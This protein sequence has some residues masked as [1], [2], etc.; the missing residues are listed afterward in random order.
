MP[1]PMKRKW[2]DVSVPIKEGM[3][4]WPGDPVVRIRNHRSIRK[5]DLCNVSEISLG[6]HTGTH[7]DAPRHFFEHAQGLDQ[8][9]LEVLIGP[10]RIIA[11]RNKTSVTKAELG[12][13]AIKQGERILFKTHN[14][15][16]HWARN[17]E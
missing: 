7:M 10:A 6:S 12:Q 5:G 9:S 1:T 8:V 3:V 11:I 14:S 2:I 17:L 4:H 15:Q 16:R 13:Y